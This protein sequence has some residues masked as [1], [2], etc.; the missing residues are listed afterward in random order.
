[1]S[2]ALRATTDFIAIILFVIFAY[3]AYAV[4]RWGHSGTISAVLLKYAYKYPVVPFLIG[5]I[6]GHLFWPNMA[7]RLGF[8]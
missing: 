1:M 3:D 7:S 6:M 5:L 2:F 4:A 8:E